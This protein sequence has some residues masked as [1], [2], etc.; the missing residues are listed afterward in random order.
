MERFDHAI[1]EHVRESKFFP[2]IAELRERAGMSR[3]V[4]EDRAEA[5]ENWT[6]LKKFLNENYYEDLGGLKNA[7]KIP[8]RVMYAMNA[9]GGARAIYFM[10][11]ES[12]PF[13]RKD[14]LEA[15]RLAPVAAARA[16]RNALESKRVG[17]LN[18]GE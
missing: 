17:Y 8:E 3:H 4:D 14:F 15:Y 2:T 1:T 7:A 16:R 5:I 10:D 12:E 13:K 9:A 18:A 11:L 6:R